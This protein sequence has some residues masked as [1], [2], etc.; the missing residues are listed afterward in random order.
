MGL[1]KRKER[2]DFSDEAIDKFVAWLKENHMTMTAEE[3]Q[4]TLHSQSNDD[5]QKQQARKLPKQLVIPESSALCHLWQTWEGKAAHTAF[6]PMEFMYDKIEEAHEV[7]VKNKSA[8][9]SGKLAPDQNETLVSVAERRA[10]AEQKGRVLEDLDDNQKEIL[11]FES[12]LERYADKQY[13]RILQERAS[14]SAKVVGELTEAIKEQKTDVDLMN[15]RS[16]GGYSSTDEAERELAEFREQQAVPTED[17]PVEA[18]EIVP[19]DATIQLRLTEDKVRAWIFVLPPRN[20]GQDLTE[21]AL[22]AFLMQ[23]NIRYG[24]D[25]YTVR[26]LVEKRLYFKMIQIATGLDPMHGR[27][28]EVQ[29][30]VTREKKIDLREDSHGQVD[31]KELNIISSVRAGEAICHVKLPTKAKDGRTVTDEVIKGRDGKYPHVPQGRNT[32]LNEDGSKLLATIDGEV[33]FEA[34]LFRVQRLLTIPGDV[35]TAVGNVDFPGDVVIGGDVREGFSVKA[36]GRI[37]IKGTVEGAKLY[38]EGDVQIEHGMVGGQKGLIECSGTLR[39][40]YLENCKVYAKGKVYVENIV[41]SDVASDDSVVITAERGSITGGK[42]TAASF[43]NAKTIGSRNNSGLVTKIF[44]GATPHM[45]E[46]EFNLQKK[47]ENTEANIKKLQKNISYIESGSESSRE[48]RKVILE[49]LK[50]QLQMRN[51]QKAQVDRQLATLTNTMY[52]N[53][54]KCQLLFEQLFPTVT[55]SM[56]GATITLKDPMQYGKAVFSNGEVRVE[57]R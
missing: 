17:A 53:N 33:V 14:A 1:F 41:F 13:N 8:L 26:K 21:E 35:D 38:A 56:A 18:V 46:Q 3:V 30:L 9:R 50:I 2:R 39:C 31:Y 51:L 32:Q 27:N 11:N 45:L 40:R 49:Q 10:A 4:A 57:P 20:G 36:G 54:A 16:L 44:L 52:Q 43:V 5:P 29:E 12:E 47:Q 24:V 23:N 28:G 37:Y 34:G 55:I 42:I 22:L 15:L 7:W 48:E 6:E 25:S 19:V